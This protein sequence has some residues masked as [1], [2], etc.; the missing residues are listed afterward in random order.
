MGDEVM[1]EQAAALTQALLGDNRAGPLAKAIGAQVNEETKEVRDQ[2]QAQLESS[3]KLLQ[4][5]IA[6]LRE[7]TREGPPGGGAGVQRYNAPPWAINSAVGAQ[8]LGVP[9]ANWHNPDAEGAQLDGRFDS[10]GDFM[11][12]ML[13]RD[14]R[15]VA[16]DR[17]IDVSSSGD[18]RRE[19]ALTGEE[20]ELGGALV[21][22][23][24]RPQ[25]LTLM[26]QPTSIRSRATVLPMMSS[27]I[28]IPAIRDTDHSN[29][30]VFGGVSFNWLEVLEEIEETEPEFAMI[31]LVARALAGRTDLPNTLIEDSF[32]TIPALVMSLW[33][34]AVPWIEESVFIR[35]DGVG[36]PRG[37]L[38]SPAR[39]NVSRET[40]SEFN[41]PDIFNMISHLLPGSLGRAVF[42]YNPEAIAQIGT[43]TNGDVQVWMPNLATGMPST[44]AGIPAIANEHM[45]ALGTTGDFALVDWMYYLIADRQALS[46]AAS[47]HQRFSNNIT[48]L[49]GIE[50]L[51][52]R[53]WLDEPITPAQG[54][55][56]YQ[57]SPFVVLDAST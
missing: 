31:R 57:M 10:F 24:F 21:P 20:M 27:S 15:G 4:D 1:E 29:G 5:D 12:A 46:M 13:R 33:R 38:E 18:V 42:M 6:A 56:G 22:E 43:L 35:G 25:L 49:R 45:S 16:D 19:A 51:D 52:G 30:N 55:T 8:V 2:I 26:L 54:S 11:L 48:V 44:I 47:P 34:Q 39:V 32:T 36:K 3:L 14:R 7:V 28:T 23:E 37:I 9:D 41:V 53:A 50:R 40:A 17:L